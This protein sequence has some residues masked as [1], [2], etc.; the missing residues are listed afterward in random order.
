MPK[1]R[2]TAPLLAAATLQA[3][4][5]A[6]AA[7]ASPAAAPLAAIRSDSIALPDDGEIFDDETLD[8]H[9]LA[10]HSPAMVLYQPALSRKQWTDV[11]A[12]M[13]TT[14]KAPI[15]EDQTQAIIDALMAKAP[16]RP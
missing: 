10:C 11:V 7:P 3:A 1:L 15:E 5:A 9:C 13:R 16:S 14:Y 6:A 8:T 12:K 4:L 2:H